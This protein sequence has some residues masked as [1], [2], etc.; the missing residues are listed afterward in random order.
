M[1]N[2]AIKHQK[3]NN[4]LPSKVYSPTDKANYVLRNG[5]K[6]SDLFGISAFLKKDAK[7]IAI[8]DCLSQTY[9]PQ[10]IYVS[11]NLIN[12]QTGEIFDGYGV[13]QSGIAS[14][15]SPAYQQSASRRARKRAENQILR[16]KRQS[17]QD[18]RFLTLTM[19]HLKADVATVLAIESKAIEL[20]KKRKLWTQN[21]D[22]AFFG[23]E[24]TIGD[25]STKVFTHY[26]LHTHCLM[27]GKYM[28]QWKIAD[29]W[30]N[31]VEKACEQFGVEFLMTN[32]KTN[33][34]IV[35]IRDVKKYAKKRS[36]TM[37]DSLAELCKYTTK[38]SEFEKVPVSELVEI[39]L[40]LRGRQMVKT[41]GD[42]NKRKG[43]NFN[44]D[45][46]V[47]THHTID[48]EV[49]KPRFKRNERKVKSLVNLGEKMIIEGKREEWLKILNLTM[50]TRRKFRRDYLAFK[51]PHATFSTLDGATWVG[52][53]RPPTEH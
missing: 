4:F 43:T 39:E 14:R 53:S 31:C 28:E 22:G 20:F 33:R 47:H 42:F 34:L 25:S 19:P 51:Y 3:S 10:N 35:D 13:L 26:H 50:E 6:L 24:M 12:Y 40:A 52:V 30:T 1:G 29:A 37:A 38:G 48:G 5:E 7:A 8:A 49:I 32:L 2:L 44:K 16:V 9:K 41:Y 36:I 15:L 17:G 45:T 23:E 27:L 21:V 11:K 18:W 46:Y